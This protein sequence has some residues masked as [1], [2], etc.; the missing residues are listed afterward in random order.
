MA[1]V[2]ELPPYVHN[3]KLPSV[4]GYKY[5]IEK[6]SKHDLESEPVLQPILHSNYD[7][8]KNQKSNHSGQL[9]K[10]I[11]CFSVANDEAHEFWR[12]S[13]LDQMDGNFRHSLV[14]QVFAFIKLINLIELIRVIL[15]NKDAEDMKSL[16]STLIKNTTRYTFPDLNCHALSMGVRL[17]TFYQHL[18]KDENIWLSM[19]IL[20]K[21][22][23]SKCSTDLLPLLEYYLV[24]PLSVFVS[25]ETNVYRHIQSFDRNYLQRHFN[26]VFLYKHVKNSS[27]W[28]QRNWKNLS[29]YCIYPTRLFQSC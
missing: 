5:L 21:E 1:E 28:F 18:E 24:C 9:W 7:K 4:A 20:I 15:K 25:P 23:Q 10:S 16:I 2:Y 17:F 6:T 14:V 11:I 22:L 26:R 8:N 27:F 29:N 13:G 3:I 19:A 12:R